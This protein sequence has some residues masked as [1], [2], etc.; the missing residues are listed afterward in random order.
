MILIMTTLRYPQLILSLALLIS[1]FRDNS[2]NPPLLLLFKQWII[3]EATRTLSILD[4]PAIK[5]DCYSPI[6]AIRFSHFRIYN[7]RSI[8]GSN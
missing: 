2:S 3:S 7:Y 1:T 6:I 5:V 8:I 4:L